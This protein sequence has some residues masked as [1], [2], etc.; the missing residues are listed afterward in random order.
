M[1]F[2]CGLGNYFDDEAARPAHPKGGPTSRYYDGG[3][4]RR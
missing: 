1:A 3:R 2:L 4:M